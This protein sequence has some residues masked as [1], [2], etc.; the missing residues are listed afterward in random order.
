[1]TGTP[2]DIIGLASLATGAAKRL[3]GSGTAAPNA[4]ADVLG[5]AQS[6]MHSSG[7]PVGLA[8]GV[9]VELSSEQLHRLAQ[10]ADRAESRGAQTAV[11][12]IDGRALEL[13][14]TLRQITGEVNP[15]QGIRP[16]VD[17]FLFAPPAD[18]PAASGPAGSTQ[19]TDLLRILSEQRDD[20]R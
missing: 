19:N 11:V 6:S 16:E 8:Q 15:D 10:A 18:Q 1:M 7:L 4:F 12:M 13:D 2:I 5:K 20:A 9:D 3:A 14:V 17:T